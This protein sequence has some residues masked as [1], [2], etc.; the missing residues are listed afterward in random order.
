MTNQRETTEPLRL[1]LDDERPAPEG[2]VWCRSVNAAI[3]LL[4]CAPVS[5]ASLDH[6]LGDYRYDGGDG[7][8][9]VD[10]MAENDCWPSDGVSVHSANP[11]G[12]QTMIA[13]INRYAPYP[14]VHASVP[15]A[16]G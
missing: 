4:S 2:W 11:V 14:G 15:Q 10:W 8:A 3:S 5:Y 1:W 16:L 9:F 7:T 12:R 13:T 6:D